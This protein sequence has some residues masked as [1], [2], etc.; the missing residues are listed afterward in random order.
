MK[1]SWTIIF[2]ILIAAIVVFVV[3]AIIDLIRQFIEK[4]TVKKVLECKIFNK[5]TNLLQEETTKDNTIQ[6]T[7]EKKYIEISH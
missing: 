2:D 1:E 7:D 3:G 4:H 6:S 5:K